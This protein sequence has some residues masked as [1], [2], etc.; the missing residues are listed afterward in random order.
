MLLVLWGIA[1]LLRNLSP[2]KRL[3]INGDCV[4]SQYSNLKEGKWSNLGCRCSKS[5]KADAD[6]L[7]VSP[8][9]AAL[10]FKPH[11]VTRALKNRGSQSKIPS[12]GRV[13]G[14][15][16]VVTNLRQRRSVQ[17]RPPPLARTDSSALQQPLAARYR[18][19]WTDSTQLD[20]RG[21]K[22]WWRK[23]QAGSS[24]SLGS[25]RCGR[26][27]KPLFTRRFTAEELTSCTRL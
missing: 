10:G 19:A 27:N 15:R 3:I 6:E 24:S 9:P 4:R 22:I 11:G 18:A 16:T 12:L 20:F 26:T 8:P 23:N 14:F 13:L 5:S 17:F 2:G 1:N 7:L 21:G 25:V